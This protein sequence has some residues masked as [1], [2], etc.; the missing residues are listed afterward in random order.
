MRYD[1]VSA[2]LDARFNGRVFCSTVPDDP[3][4]N[5][6]VYIICRV[7]TF[8]PLFFRSSPYGFE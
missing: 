3:F 2:S 6:A 8:V 1:S 5:D 7:G 4:A